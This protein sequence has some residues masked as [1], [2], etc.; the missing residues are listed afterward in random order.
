MPS[1]PS[2]QLRALQALPPDAAT[3]ALTGLA[4]LTSVLL[5]TTGGAADAERIL[6]VAL[7]LLGFVALPIG[8]A[9]SVFALGAPRLASEVS[10]ATQTYTACGPAVQCT[11]CLDDVCEGQVARALPCGHKFHRGCVD[12]WLLVAQ[13]NTCPLCTRP[14][15]AGRDGDM[16]TIPVACGMPTVGALCK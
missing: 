3:A 9:L 7:L 12:S 16:A 8:A 6:T 15:V 4:L 5:S 2:R 13:K 14:V 11:V 10:S 1:V